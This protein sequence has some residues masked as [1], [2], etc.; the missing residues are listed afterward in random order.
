MGTYKG[1]MRFMA[2]GTIVLSLI[3]GTWGFKNVWADGEEKESGTLFNAL[4][5]SQHTLADGI[6]QAT[7]GTEVA[8]SAKFEMDDNGKLSLSV[9][10]AEKGLAFDAKNNALKE[11]AGSPESQTWNPQT[12]VFTDQEHLERAGKHLAIMA[13]SKLSLLDVVEKAQKENQ[14]TVF[15]ATPEREDNMSVIEVKIAQDGKVSEHHYDIASGNEMKM[16]DMDD[17]DEY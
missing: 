3:L 16:D 13:K 8:I 11:L 2:V 7:N 4:P 10:T 12:E 6:R 5:L 9:Y 17:D 1:A 14:G 15:A